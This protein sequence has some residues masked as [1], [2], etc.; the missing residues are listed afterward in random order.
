MTHA[1]Q[2]KFNI[3]STKDIAGQLDHP[4]E[5]SHFQGTESNLTNKKEENKAY[6]ERTAC[7]QDQGGAS[8]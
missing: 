3:Q 5:N 4:E 6:M 8:S 7:W 2:I 1:L